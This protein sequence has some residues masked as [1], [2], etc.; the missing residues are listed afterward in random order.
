[1]YAAADITYSSSSLRALC[2]SQSCEQLEG[3]A[4]ILKFSGTKVNDIFMVT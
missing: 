2:G 1:M 4:V 3:E